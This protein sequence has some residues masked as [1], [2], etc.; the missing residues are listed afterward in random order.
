MYIVLGLGFG[1]DDG[2]CSDF[3]TSIPAF[4]RS[5]LVSLLHPEPKPEITQKKWQSPDFRGEDELGQAP[6]ACVENLG[7]A[8]GSGFD[9]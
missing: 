6:E 3:T 9:V 8:V 1:W 5:R 7:P 2:F 4:V